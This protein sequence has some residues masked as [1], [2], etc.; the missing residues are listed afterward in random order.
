MH[1]QDD[2]R[3]TANKTVAFGSHVPVAEQDPRTALREQPRG[4]EILTSET[5]RIVG[6]PSHCNDVVYVG[7]II[8]EGRFCDSH[9]EKV[10]YETLSLQLQNAEHF[11]LSDSD[12]Q[13][14]SLQFGIG[15][16]RNSKG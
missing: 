12:G 1:W 5:M 6:K 2:Q 16:T 4:Y 10:A 15:A 3:L 8:N 14:S 11:S 13:Q 9:A 7:H